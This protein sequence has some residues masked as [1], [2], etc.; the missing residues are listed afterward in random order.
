MSLGPSPIRLQTLE[1]MTRLSRLPPRFFEGLAQE[2]FAAAGEVEVGAVDEVDAQVDGGFDGADR[3]GC[4]AAVVPVGA[5]GG[6]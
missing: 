3:G 6:A 5:E 2:F 4:V 1:V